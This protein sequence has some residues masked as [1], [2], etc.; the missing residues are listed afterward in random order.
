MSR[1]DPDPAGFV[2]VP[3]VINWPPGSERNIYGFVTLLPTYRFRVI[4][5]PRHPGSMPV[6]TWYLSN[7]VRQ[8]G[9]VMALHFTITYI[10]FFSSDYINVSTHWEVPSE[11]PT[12][13][14]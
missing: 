4:K 5:H 14:F 1:Y 7:F 11:T 9:S 10:I 8:I 3:S 12:I 6:G 2:S 13:F